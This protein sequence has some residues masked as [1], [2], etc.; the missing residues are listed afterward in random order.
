MTP[1]ERITTEVTSWDGIEA[2]VGKRGEFGFRLGKREIGHL[3][4]DHAA[5]FFFGKERWEELAAQGR[6]AEH[7]VFAGRHGPAARRIEDDADVADVIALMRIN[8]DD[9]KARA[10]R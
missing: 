10:T 7:P 2:G 3:H 1:S 6:I 8:Y 5:H 9:V 4:G